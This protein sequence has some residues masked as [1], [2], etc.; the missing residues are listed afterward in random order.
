[1]TPYVFTIDDN[2]RFLQEITEQGCAPFAHPYFGL[3]LRLHARYGV[4]IQLNLFFSY[5]PGGFSL[6]EV[7]DTLRTVFEQNADWLRVSFHA[8]HNDPPFPYETDTAALQRDY[9]LGMQ[10]LHRIAG[11]AVAKTTTLHYVAATKQGCAALRRAGVRGLV[12]MF[13]ENEQ[14]PRCNLHYYL[15]PQ[16]CASVRETGLWYDAETDLWFLRNHLI[17]NQL[18]REALPQALAAL[19]QQAVYHIMIHEQ[20]FYPDYERY[21]PDFAQKLELALEFFTRQGAQSVFFETLCSALPPDT[22]K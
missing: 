4:K 9:S 13:Y 10:Q 12:G 22:A 6:C 18:S 11:S 17:L 8:R 3:L 19:P 16:Q 7:P 20:Y 14:P 5:A 1:M 21:Q 2:I 15:T